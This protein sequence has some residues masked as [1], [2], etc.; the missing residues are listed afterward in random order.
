[1]GEDQGLH[2]TGTK[3]FN[4]DLSQQ[5]FLNSSSNSNSQH[6]PT[7]YQKASFS[8]GLKTGISAIGEIER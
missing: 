2:N 1:M 5:A 4:Q 3:C 6:T 7:A 8:K